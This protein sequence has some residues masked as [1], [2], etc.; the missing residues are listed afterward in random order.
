MD[1]PRDLAELGRHAGLDDDGLPTAS[2]DRGPHEYHVL[3]VPQ[4]GIAGQWLDRL[5][6]GERFPGQ[7]RFVHA[8]A[9]DFEESCVGGDPVTRGEDRHVAWH[10]IARGHRHGASLPEDV[11]LRGGEVLQGLQGPFRSI[12][13]D[14]TEDRV[15]DHDDDD[16]HGV[17]QVRT[18]ALQEPQDRRDDRSDDQD[19]HEDVHELAQQDAERTHPRRL[20]EFIRPEPSQPTRRLLGIQTQGGGVKSSQD[21]VGRQGMPVVGHRA[22]NPRCRNKAHLGHPWEPRRPHRVS[23]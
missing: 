17:V 13:L 23:R 3:A 10:E 4:E 7:R 14:E 2:V 16:Q 21:G 19:D 8:E 15:H 6:D 9:R 22:P 1:E 12:F 18:L 5:A 20:N 11:G